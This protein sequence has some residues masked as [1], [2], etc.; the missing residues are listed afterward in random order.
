RTGW[1]ATFGEELAEDG[2][3][4]MALVLAVAAEGKAGQGAGGRESGVGSRVSDVRQMTPRM[5]EAKD[6]RLR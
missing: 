6:A 4:A 1:R 2:A 3:V 5:M